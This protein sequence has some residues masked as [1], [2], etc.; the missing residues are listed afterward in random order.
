MLNFEYGPIML[1]IH[2]DKGYI[3]GLES[4]AVVDLT[5]CKIIT[6]FH[7][8]ECH[9]CYCNTVFVD[10]YY[11]TSSLSYFK[12]RFKMTSAMAS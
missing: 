10:N 4:R 2:Q 6:I 1:L 9:S 12:S 5:M 8:M 11:S 7:V 3:A